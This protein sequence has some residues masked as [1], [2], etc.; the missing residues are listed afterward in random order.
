MLNTQF[1]ILAVQITY[2]IRIE[3][4]IGWKE[5][6]T[7]TRSNYGLIHETSKRRVVRGT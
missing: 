2:V 7:T 3:L 6:I 5:N 4:V 1:G